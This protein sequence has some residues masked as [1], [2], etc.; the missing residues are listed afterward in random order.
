MFEAVCAACES[1]KDYEP[2]AWFIHIQWL[3]RL[4]QSGYPFEKDDLDIEEWLGIGEMR[5][6]IEE[7]KAGV[8]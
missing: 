8:K 6:A 4:Q 2:S 1:N 5:E 3:Y 7:L